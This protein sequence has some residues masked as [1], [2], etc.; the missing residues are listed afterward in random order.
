MKMLDYIM[1]VSIFALMAPEIIGL[2]REMI[3]R[4]R[5]RK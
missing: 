1:A 2:F 3:D 4:I 5:R